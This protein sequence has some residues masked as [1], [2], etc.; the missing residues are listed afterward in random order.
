[1]IDADPFVIDQMPAEIRR[2]VGDH[3]TGHRKLASGMT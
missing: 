1:M 3:K 2:K